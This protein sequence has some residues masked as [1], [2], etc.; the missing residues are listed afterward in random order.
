MRDDETHLLL[1]GQLGLLR[2]PDGVH[3]LEDALVLAGSGQQAACPLLP[4]PEV[5]EAILEVG[6]LLFQLP[7]LLPAQ[8]QAQPVKLL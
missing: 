5:G 2:L 4:L 7:H 8:H 3:E 6:P 1:E